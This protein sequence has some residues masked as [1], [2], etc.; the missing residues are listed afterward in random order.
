VCSLILWPNQYSSRIPKEPALIAVASGEILLENTAVQESKAIPWAEPD[1]SGNEQ[2]YVAD[3]L[4]SSWISGGPY[5]ELFEERFRN[6]Y[7]TRYAMTSS[8]GTTALHMAFLA[9]GI[10]P[11]DEVIVPGFA[12]MAAANVALH[13][14]AKPVFAEVDPET[15]CMRAKDI[16]RQISSKVK[17]IVAVHTYGSLCAMDE[18]A[19]LGAAHSIPVLEDA[20]EAL[21]CRYKNRLAGSQGILGTFSFHASKTITT[22]EGGMVI[23]DS[24]ELHNRLYLIR[25]HGVHTKRYWHELPGHNFRLTNM[26]AAV[27]CAQ[28]ERIDEFIRERKRVYSTYQ[29]CLGGVH[30]VTMQKFQPDVEPVVWAVAVKLESAA[31]PQ[32]RDTVI[33]QLQEDGI[34]T[35]NG[36]YAATMLPY[37]HATEKLDICEDLSRQVIS[38]PT[39]A[40]LT[41]GQIDLVCGKLES[42]RK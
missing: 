10:G 24:P 17:L 20:A 34:E 23:T 42:L 29:K 9:L 33:R 16:E 30:G 15:W 12:F 18:I 8:N 40:G 26:Q 19:A 36:F 39:F 32:G 21:A 25:N 11:G 3:A 31:F 13:L 7:G 37:L 4:S 27:G 35:R 22:G 14:G 41:D 2:R 38:L 6:Y 5:I 28:L 1:L